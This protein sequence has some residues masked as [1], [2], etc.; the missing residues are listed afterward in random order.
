MDLSVPV[1]GSAKS[2]YFRLS[3]CFYPSMTHIPG[4]ITQLMIPTQ[5]LSLFDYL[6]F[7]SSLCKIK[8]SLANSSRANSS[9]ASG[10]AKQKNLPVTLLPEGSIISYCSFCLF[11]TV[12]YLHSYDAGSILCFGLFKRNYRSIISIVDI[13]LDFL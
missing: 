10:V 13:I 3:I 11:V 5:P 4:I 1:K 12:Q 9:R 6:L 7:F 8:S 2:I